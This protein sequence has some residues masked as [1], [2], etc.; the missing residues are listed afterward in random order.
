MGVFVFCTI[1]DHDWW[2]CKSREE[3]LHKAKNHMEN[4]GYDP[5]DYVIIDGQLLAL[6]PPTSDY[7][8]E[9]QK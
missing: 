8:L 1:D 6:I 5:E 4:H 3:A 9:E 2:R 7:Y